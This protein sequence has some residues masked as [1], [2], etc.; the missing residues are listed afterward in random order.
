MNRT[1]LLA[2]VLLTAGLAGCLGGEDAALEESNTTETTPAVNESDLGTLPDGSPVPAETT[3]AGCHEQAGAFPVPRAFFE[4]EVPDGFEPVPF[5]PAGASATLV[6]ISLS[7]S[8]SGEDQ[9]VLWGMLVVEPPEGLAPEDGDVSLLAL[10]TISSDERQAHVY[11][12]WG[13][14]DEILTGDVTVENLQETNLGRGGHAMAT[15]GDFTIHMYSSVGGEPAP[16]TAG[17]ARVFGESGGELAG[18]MDISW[19][20]SEGGFQDG[21]ATLAFEGQAPIP[22]P[23][24]AGVAW[25]FWGDSYDVTFEHLDLSGEA[26]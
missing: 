12:A 6:V 26:S 16:E 15:D 21:E 1:L 24:S 3:L 14:G 13:L 17:Q 11:E 22:Q 2:V 5:G 25:H 7:C 20:D 4:G 10:G 9:R 23:E 19:T 8:L 18:A